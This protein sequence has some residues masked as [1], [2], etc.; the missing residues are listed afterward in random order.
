MNSSVEL[1]FSQEQR[2][3][4]DRLLSDTTVDSEL[5]WRSFGRTGYR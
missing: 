3:E 2:E 1:V 5:V 4:I